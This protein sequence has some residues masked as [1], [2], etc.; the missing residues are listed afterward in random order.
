MYFCRVLTNYSLSITIF[1]LIF[2]SLV[3][4]TSSLAIEQPTATST[5]E[6]QSTTT[7]ETENYL[8]LDQPNMSD[9]D[10]LQ[11]ANLVV[12]LPYS[13]DYENHEERLSKAATYFSS[14]GWK[15]VEVAIRQA[16][17][18]ERIIKNKTIVSARTTGRMRILRQGVLHGRYTW[19]VY[20]PMKV[21]YRGRN[22]THGMK[23]AVN[24]WITRVRPSVSSS[25]LLVIRY[26]TRIESVVERTNRNINNFAQREPVL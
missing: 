13:Y 20:V 1:I 4:P 5:Q 3:T 11:W 14:E 16:G 26:N 24:M 15:N 10:L 18:I 12:I 17:S 19:Q 22:I 9:A 2:A 21:Y 23:M 8:P 6:E 25:G 7:N